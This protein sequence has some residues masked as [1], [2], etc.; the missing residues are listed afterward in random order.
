MTTVWLNGALVDAARAALP[1]DDPAVRH[2][3]G[4]LETMRA[5]GGR[6]PWLERHLD[7]LARSAAALGLDGLPGRD[8]VAKGVA[9]ALGANPGARQ[10]V[11]VSVTARPT[12]L[13]EVS[14][15]DGA[16]PLAPEAA[17]RALHGA[18]LPTRALAE[19]K[20]LSRAGYRQAAAAARAA[21]AAHAL[22]LDA[23]G[24]LGEADGA[25]AFCVLAGGIVTAP[26]RGLLP[27][28]ARALVL[29]LAGAREE[30][31]EEPVWRTADELFL[32]NAVAR[33]IPITRVDGRQVGNGR[34]GPVTRDVATALGGPSP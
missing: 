29:E 19:H 31:P 12:L 13:V 27:G 4:L 33:V 18:W 32:T 2:G 1:I 28:I 3:E 22:L 11:R 15:L 21:G 20:T 9:A 8:A 23:D 26:A 24:R 34:P 25:N 6:V 10:R 5:E 16:G 17:A 30:A 7:R 14:P